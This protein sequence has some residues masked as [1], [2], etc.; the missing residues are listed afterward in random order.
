MNGHLRHSAWL[1]PLVALLSVQGCSKH[2]PTLPHCVI[3]SYHQ[4]IA[5]S[6]HDAM[7]VLFVIDDS[8]TMAKEQALLRHELP[9]MLNLLLAGGA[10]DPAYEKSQLLIPRIQDL[11]IAVISADMGTST[12]LGVPGC[13]STG[14]DGVLRRGQ[15]CRDTP[16]FVWDYR[17][18]HDPVQS[19]LAVSCNTD[20]GAAG[21]S[22][23]QPLE[24]ML[25]ALSPADPRAWTG[26]PSAPPLAPPLFLDGTHGHGMDDNA[27]FLRSSLDDGLSAVLVVIITDGDD[28]SAQDPAL[29]VPPEQLGAGDPLH[30]QPLT[31]RC[32]RNAQRL[33]PIRRYVNGLRALRPGNEQLVHVA[34]IAGVPPDLVDDSARQTLISFD[35]HSRDG[36]YTRILR[37]PRMQPVT[38]TGWPTEP[39]AS[40]RPSCTAN[41]ATAYPPQRLVELAWQLG[42]NATLGSLCA[43]DLT[44]AVFD[45]L[46]NFNSPHG[47]GVCLQTHFPR[48][49]RGLTSCRT[50]WELPAVHNAGQPLTP[51]S[52][53]DR[54]DLLSTPR[55]GRPERG[56]HGGPLCEVN[57]LAVTRDPKTGQLAAHAGEGVYLDDFSQD[58]AKRCLPREARFAFTAHAQPPDGVTVYV[59]CEDLL[60][61]QAS[62]DA[63][64]SDGTQAETCL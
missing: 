7:D 28:C 56:E 43:G 45:Q 21:C 36:F 30:A 5:V 44:Q 25:K 14:D 16:D 12:P 51:S 23:A 9:R 32:A 55:P 29:F 42:E 53:A 38:Q 18:Y 22:F 8:P 57:Q 33:Q 2:A 59:D 24:A 26:E 39:G 54:P 6:H 4:Q 62:D 58:R 63:G 31:E 13:S 20:L 61:G 11:H 48:D 37:D 46:G 60:Q 50:T 27:G 3:R 49:A 34:V 19:A 47:D 52:C 40:L 10:G 15:H 17:G 1:A 41:G 35:P 64:A